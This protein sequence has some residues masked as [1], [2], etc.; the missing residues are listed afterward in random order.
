MSG[1]HLMTESSSSDDRATS[2]EWQSG[3]ALGQVILK[4]RKARP[5]LARHPWVLATAVASIAGQPADGDV[6]DVVSDNGAF[7]AR[8][9]LNRRSHV[10]V[11]LYS[12]DQGELLDAEFWERQLNRAIRWRQRLGLRRARRG[13]TLSVQ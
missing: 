5:F 11:R 8:G 10:R 9:I 6:V 7:I 4:P 2:T 12:W 3:Q 1:A 13:R